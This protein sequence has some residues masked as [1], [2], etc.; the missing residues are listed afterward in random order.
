MTSKN[1]QKQ[2]YADRNEKVVWG[3]RKKG[4]ELTVTFLVVKMSVSFW[5]LVIPIETELLK[6]I[7]LKT[8]WGKG[9]CNI[10]HTVKTK[11]FNMQEHIGYLI[12]SWQVDGNEKVKEIILGSAPLQ[13]HVEI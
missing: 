10:L 7:D 6:M 11:D 9:P 12:K 2:I 1:R 3:V 13:T 8:E 5:L 4:G